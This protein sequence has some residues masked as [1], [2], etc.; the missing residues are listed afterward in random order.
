M[1]ILEGKCAVITGSGRGLGK[2]YALLFAKEGAKIVVND[3]DRDVAEETAA[4]IKKTGGTAVVSA[5]SVYP[6]DSAGKII[7][8]CVDSFG[9]IDILVNNAGIVRD[10]TVWNMTV[11]DFDDVI[12][13]HL[14]GTFY[15]G[16]HAIRLMRAQRGGTILNIVSGAHHGNF[17]QTNY[18]A[19][20]GG[21]ASMTYTWA[22]ELARSN[23]RV[24]A[25]APSGDT[26][27]TQSMPGPVPGAAN[28]KPLPAALSA[29]LIAYLCSDECFWVHGQVF[30]STGETYRIMKQPT[31]WTGMVRPGGWDIPSLKEYF[32]KTYY[33][34]LEN[35]GLGKPLYAY[36]NGLPKPEDKK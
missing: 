17:G 20:K 4:E 35:F 5:D 8:K 29:P 14:K 10:K 30:N 3:V 28:R 23:I 36:Y 11:E 9:R 21:I 24:N 34:Q 31:Y 16:Q 7:Q 25:V 2:E 19:A 27:M 18:S 22:V 32:K 6:Y 15:C 26:R 33:G 12:N 13:V 1:G